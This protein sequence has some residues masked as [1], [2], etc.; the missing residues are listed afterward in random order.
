[1]LVKKQKIQK[2][3]PLRIPLNEDM[4]K[5]FSTYSEMTGDF[6]EGAV[7]KSGEFTTT[8]TD[9]EIQEMLAN[10][11]DNI[12]DISDLI[13]YNYISN[14]TIYQL[15]TIYK[16][17]P[18]LNYKIGAFDNST[19][20]YE[21]SISIVNRMLHKVRY[22]E[23]TRDIIGQS[24]LDGGV[25]TMWCGAKNNLFLYVF[26][27]LEYV[28]P[29]YRLNG[30]WVCV[31]DMA[32]L[33]EMEEEERLNIFENLSPYV[34]E[35]M[36]KK[37]EGDSSNNEV[38]YIALPQ[39]RTT[40]IRSG[41]YLRRNQRVGIPLGT[42]ALLD[43]NHKQQLKNME[44][45]VANRAIKNIAVL[46][47][48]SDKEGK[49]YIDIGANA[50]KQI[51]AGVGKALKQSTTANT[52]Q[53]PVATIPEFCKLEFNRTD[54]MDA[55][56]S[57]KY[58]GIDQDLATD[59]GVSEGLARGSGSNNSG[60]VINLEFLYKRIGSILEQ[61][62]LVFEKMIKLTLGKKEAEN[63]YFEFDKAQ[64]ISKETE[65]EML[66]KLEAQGYSV[67]AIIDRISGV[68]FDDYIEESLYELQELK[69]RE[70]IMPPL[71]SYT[72]SSDSTSSESSETTEEDTKTDAEE[73]V[74]EAT[75]PAEEVVEEGE[76]SGTE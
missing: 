32:M 15:Y 6:V 35:A 24:S 49:S 51:V 46:Q 65:L 45:S 12:Q 66:Y 54:G 28:F 19:K 17:L 58:E 11:E 36:Y 5:A 61:V 64:P 68:N 75:A 39:E 50:R 8:Y 30:D 33:Q 70:H 57:D 34:T 10:P 53:V 22:K 21:E 73:N 74:E 37:F 13:Y 55:L 18:T 31:I 20:K 59:T 9:S 69:L 23:V 7:T 42:Q 52:T 16:S 26:D 67:K 3:S 4:I 47:I 56:G 29:K 41:D 76:G 27:N 44:K 48:G 14:G 43:I 2:T 60:A 72:M 1:M 71:S 25:V 63:L 62:D 40:Y 38:R